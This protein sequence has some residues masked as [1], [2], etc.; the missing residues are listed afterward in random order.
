VNRKSVVTV[1]H[2]V[3]GT[4][5]ALKA[6]SF[7]PQGL[8]CLGKKGERGVIPSMINLSEA[9]EGRV[10]TTGGKGESLGVTEGP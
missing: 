1:Q 3:G 10:V 8:V 9:G 2:R 4:G 6:R 7:C 5:R